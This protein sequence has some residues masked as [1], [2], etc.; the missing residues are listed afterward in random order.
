MARWERR[1]LVLEDLKV[2]YSEPKN[3]RILLIDDNEQI[4]SDIRKVLMPQLMNEALDDVTMAILGKSA[5]RKKVD[6]GYEI[7]SAYQGEEGFQMIVDAKAADK[8]YAMAFVD[9][10][11]PPGWD[12]VETITNIWE[13]DPEVQIVIC[14]AYSDY[15]WDQIIERFGQTDKLLVL[16]KPFD[17]AEV[18]QLA[19][20]LTT[21]WNLCLQAGMKMNLL[22]EMVDEQ[23]RRLRNTNDVLQIEVEERRKVED[24]LRHSAFHDAL[25]NLPNRALLIERLDRC[26]ERSKRNEGYYF[27][28]LYLDLDNF[29]VVNDSLGHRVGDGLLCEIGQRLTNCLRRLD[30]TVQPDDDTTARMGGDEFVVLLDGLRHPDDAELVAQRLLEHFEEPFNIYEKE[31]MAKMSIGICSSHN[32]YNDPGDM[33]RDADTAL[34]D[35]KDHGKGCYSIFNAEMR[36]KAV[37]R[38]Q[39]ETDLRRAV[40]RNQFRLQYQPIVELNTGKIVGVEALIRWHHPEMG[41]IAPL[42]FIPLSEETGVINMMGDWIITEACH[43]VKQWQVEF[44]KYSDLSVSIN[45]STRQ[46]TG[47]ELVKQ[48][49]KVLEETGL[50]PELVNME[51]TESV[52]MEDTDLTRKIIDDLKGLGVKL[53]MD[54]FG[55]GYSS[56]SYL[57]T[58]PIDALKLDQAFIRHMGDNGEHGATVQAVITLAMN[59]GIEVIAEGVETASQLAQLQ[60]LNCELGQGY[61]FSRPLDVEKMAMLLSTGS[62]WLKSA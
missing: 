6:L 56:L 27:A 36:A 43:Q 2:M 62:G 17:S 21:K 7:D 47:S 38:L 24:R 23:T 46:I 50:T 28:V 42:D 35:A 25:T 51:I 59:R 19:C 9:M 3:N 4:H 8:P 22:S 40:E 53:H 12:G 29:K 31:I 45:L 39:L 11:M 18:Q 54:D 55:T 34:Y 41:V 14:S 61:Y 37:A 26:I 32:S 30:T 33:L 5:T 44:P 1:T 10:R 48:V 15:S 58:L 20:A 52:M 13:A 60:A 49:N 16:R 57:H